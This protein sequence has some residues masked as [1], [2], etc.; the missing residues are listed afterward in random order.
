MAATAEMLQAVEARF[1]EM[2]TEFMQQMT[3]MAAEQARLAS[4]V[5][6]AEAR[7]TAAESAA[8]STRRGG[9]FGTEAPAD[10]AKADRWYETMLKNEKGLPVFTG[11]IGSKVTFEEFKESLLAQVGPLSIHAYEA[12]MRA[13]EW[14]EAITHSNESEFVVKLSRQINGILN[15]FT[16]GEAMSNCSLIPDRNGLEKWRTLCAR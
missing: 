9:Q 6:G 2:Q 15:K 14:T 16:G 12:L 1:V 11:D 8:T 5:A 13:E 3:A 4:A 10:E 7:A